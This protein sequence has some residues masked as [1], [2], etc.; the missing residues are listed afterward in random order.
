MRSTENMS[1]DGVEETLNG[2]ERAGADDHGGQVRTA[3]GVAVLVERV[4]GLLG[5][6]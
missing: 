5:W 3:A 6:L 4:V 1:D 2:R